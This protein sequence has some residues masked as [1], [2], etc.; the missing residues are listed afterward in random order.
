MFQVFA[1]SSVCSPMLRPVTRSFTSGTDVGWTQL[2]K[3]PDTLGRAARLKH[4]TKPIRQILPQR[5]LDAAH[6]FDAADQCQRRAALP[7]HPGRLE[8][9]DHAG[10]A[11]HD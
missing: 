1:I 2:A 8:R 9:T 10:T 11:L 7:Q 5:D 4:S 3:Q 6:A